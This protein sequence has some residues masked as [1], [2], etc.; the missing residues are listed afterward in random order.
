MESVR[1]FYGVP[2]YRGRK[3]TYL[4]HSTPLRGEIMSSTGSRLWL[5]V[6]GRRMGPVHP[7]IKMDYG[8]G[9]HYTAETAAR[10]AAFNRALNAP[11][12][13]EEDAK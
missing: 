4:G 9:R 10:I 12:F 2:A 13:D 6:N 1:R 3:V 5:R 11:A 8:D 7:T